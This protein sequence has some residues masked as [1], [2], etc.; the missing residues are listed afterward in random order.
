MSKL[1][2][3]TLFAETE[4]PWM[5]SAGG[6]HA[7][8]SALRERARELKASAAGSGASTLD[9]LASYDRSS[10]SWRTSQRSLVEGWTLFS[11]TWPRSGTT[12]GGIAYQLPP[13][14]HL[15]DATGFGLLPTPKSQDSRG[16]SGKNV[17]GGPSLTDVLRKGFLP[18]PAARDWKGSVSGPKL[19]ERA[20]MT[21]GVSLEEHLLRQRL[22]TPSAGSSH[23]AGR[24]DEWGGKNP[25]RGTE[26]GRLHLSPSFVEELMGF[27]IGH[28]A[29]EPSE[30]P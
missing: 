14:A 12:V 5:S 18:T 6:S 4:L 13:L 29:L 20:S 8:T 9:S 7:R 16:G 22:P 28:T 3:P 21:R 11:E 27:P 10:C 30:T 23:S 15:T 25:F 1:S 26:I 2:Q 24:L 17:Q 19:S